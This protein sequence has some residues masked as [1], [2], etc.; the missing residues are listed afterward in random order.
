MSTL[1]P[2]VGAAGS[3]RI[4]FGEIGRFHFLIMKLVEQAVPDQ[5]EGQGKLHRVIQVA[6]VGG[7]ERAGFDDAEE[8]ILASVVIKK[9]WRSLLEVFSEGGGIKWQGSHVDH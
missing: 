4:G 2:L 8:T 3:R 5:P 9:I 6:D 1:F 7:P